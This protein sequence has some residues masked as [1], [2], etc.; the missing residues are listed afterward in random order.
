MN[1]QHEDYWGTLQ[2][3]LEWRAFQWPNS[4]RNITIIVT[5]LLG[6]VWGL[7]E[8]IWVECQCLAHTW[9]V[10]CGARMYILILGCQSRAHSIASGRPR[11]RLPHSES[12]W[13]M[14]EKREIEQGHPRP[15]RGHGHS[16]E[17][18]FELSLPSRAKTSL[19]NCPHMASFFFFFN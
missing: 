6:L 12:S 14:G 2:T 3:Q 13:V 4:G 9:L 7:N 8:L 10:D 17:R 19:T 5:S 1:W 15:L 11:K 16:E 18:G